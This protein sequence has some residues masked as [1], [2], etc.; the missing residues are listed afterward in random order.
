[1][2]G[3]LDRRKALRVLATGGAAA[4][5]AALPARAVSAPIEAPHEALGMLYDTTRCIGCKAC[6][7]ACREANDLEPDT[8]PDGLHLMPPDLNSRTKNVIKLYKEGPKVSFF[9]AQCMHCVDP[10]CVNACMLHSLEKDP[11]TGIVSYDP[12]YCVGCRY[13]QMACPFNVPKFEFEKALPKIVKCE[14][15]R[16]RFPKDMKAALSGGFS[17]F[18][19]GQGPACCEVC[20]REA[21]IYGKRSE[22]LA[23]AKRRLAAHPGRYVPKVYGEH[24]AGGTQVLYLS[25]VPFEKLGLPDLPESV[26]ATMRRVQHGVYKGFVAPVALYIALGA[27]MIRNR[28]ARG[29]APNEEKQP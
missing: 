2:T 11:V 23:E 3:T 6:V 14:L 8:G 22:L 13:C 12:Y 5:A 29:G 4:G 18:A 24:D 10:A 7:V 26:P 1:M 19:K 16:H 21:V 27:V 25:H 28:R 20:P 9:K 17:R 15:C